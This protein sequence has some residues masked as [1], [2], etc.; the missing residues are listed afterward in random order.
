MIKRKKVLLVNFKTEN[1]TGHSIY[2]NFKTKKV[3]IIDEFED[4]IEFIRENNKNDIKKDEKIV[5]MNIIDLTEV[6]S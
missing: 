1:I 4:I 5:I 6:L 3:S 2:K